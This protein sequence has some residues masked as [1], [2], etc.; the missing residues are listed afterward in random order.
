[1]KNRLLGLSEYTGGKSVEVTS[2]IRTKQQNEKVG[3]A[4]QSPH[5]SS[6]AAD[7]AIEGQ[8][9]KQTEKD[10]FNSGQF[11]RTNNY[12]GSQGIHVDTNTPRDGTV[13]LYRKW[14]AIPT[15]R[16]KPTPPKK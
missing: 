10:A 4:E 5:L 11:S 8:T 14:V 13:G 3:G 15:P 2:G 7:I 9:R 12:E 16:D 6:N 1:M